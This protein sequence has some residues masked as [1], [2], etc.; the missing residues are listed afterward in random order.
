MVTVATRSIL[1]DDILYHEEIVPLIELIEHAV[2]RTDEVTHLLALGHL[3]AKLGRLLA[4]APSARTPK[5]Q[6]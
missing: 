1:N 5:G 2:T 4:S 6:G 3:H